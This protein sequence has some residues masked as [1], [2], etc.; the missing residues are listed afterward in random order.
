MRYQN[1]PLARLQ[2]RTPDAVFLVFDEH[3]VGVIGTLA[4]IL[5]EAEKID[6]RGILEAL[7]G[8]H[9]RTQRADLLARRASRRRSRVPAGVLRRSIRGAR[10]RNL[11]AIRV[12]YISGGSTM[13]ESAEISLYAAIVTSSDAADGFRPRPTDGASRS[14][15][16]CKR[17]AAN[18]NRVKR[19]QTKI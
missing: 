13:W 5:P 4:D 8:L 14:P 12:V 19:S 15:G 11:G 2:H 9:H 18:E 1:R 17:Y 6:L 3:R 10:S 16:E 7:P